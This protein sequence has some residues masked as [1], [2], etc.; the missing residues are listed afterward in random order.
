ML[1]QLLIESMDGF[2]YSITVNKY[3]KYNENAQ[4]TTL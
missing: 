3:C 2:L 1:I 4:S